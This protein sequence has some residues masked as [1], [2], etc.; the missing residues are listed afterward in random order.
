MDRDKLQTVLDRW[1]TLEK[2][3][4]EEGI[5]FAEGL[6]L[7]SGVREDSEDADS[8]T[9]WSNVRAGDWLEKTLSELRSPEGE[10]DHSP[11]G[12]HAS[13]RPYQRAG[14]HWLR[15]LT[16]LRLGACLADDMG[17]GKTIQVLGMLLHWRTESPAAPPALLILAA[18][19][20]GNWLDEAKRFAPSLRLLA[21]HP[22]AEKEPDRGFRK[23]MLF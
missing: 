21:V 4:R 2:A 13:L 8:L 1:R 6:R 9:A 18:P 23:S 14:V 22:S 10:G 19:L 12:L 15:F 17:L 3:H 7:L 11:P 5:S 20:L 16:R